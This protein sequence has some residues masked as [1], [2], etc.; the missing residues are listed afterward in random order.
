MTA[1]TNDFTLIMTIILVSIHNGSKCLRYIN[2]KDLAS[3]LETTSQDCICTVVQGQEGIIRCR[4]GTLLMTAQSTSVASGPPDRF[5]LQP[6]AL[7]NLLLGSICFQ[8]HHC[9][10]QVLMTGD[11][12]PVTEVVS[13]KEQGLCGINL[14]LL[15]E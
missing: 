15:T 4:S 12:P 13:R 3:L 7:Q 14:N 1:T 5:R 8:I 2:T 11:P 9:L 10:V 6:D